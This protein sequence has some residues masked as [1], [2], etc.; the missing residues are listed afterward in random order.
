ML[1]FEDDVVLKASSACDLQLPLERF[2]PLNGHG[3][4][5]KTDGLPTPGMEYGLTPSEGA[6]V[7]EGPIGKRWEDGV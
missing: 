1:L 3:S 5:Q 6:Q 4:Q 2:A 7:S